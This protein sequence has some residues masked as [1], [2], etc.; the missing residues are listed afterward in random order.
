M[1]TKKILIALGIILVVII[2]F[3]VYKNSKPWMLSVYGGGQT[4]MRLDYPSKD[5][6]LSAG[7]SYI[8]DK[9]A[10]RFD[11]GY[12]CSSLDKNNLQDSPICKTVC[13]DAGCR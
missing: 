3:V 6:C 10:E 8:A 12:K 7:R 1:N 2:V 9:T 13:N 11:C 5:A 4:I